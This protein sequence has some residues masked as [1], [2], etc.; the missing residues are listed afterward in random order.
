MHAQLRHL[1]DQRYQAN[2]EIFVLPYEAGEHPDQ[3]QSFILLTFPEPEDAAVVFLDYAH[4]SVFL[5]KQH[6]IRSSGAQACVA[7]GFA[8]GWVGVRDTKNASDILVLP[9]ARFAEFLTGKK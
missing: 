2:V 4:S 9:A 7:V 3:G 5:E 1:L 8:D 6:E